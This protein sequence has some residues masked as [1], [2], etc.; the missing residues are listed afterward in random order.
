MKK[1]CLFIF[2]EKKIIFQE[3]SIY[4]ASVIKAQS[5]PFTQHANGGF[6]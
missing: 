2:F 5:E 1:T 6:H 3:T 4:K